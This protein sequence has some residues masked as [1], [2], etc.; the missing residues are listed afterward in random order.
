MPPRGLSMLAM[1]KKAIDTTRGKTN[2]K[3]P[4][5]L[6]SRAPGEDE[7]DPFEYRARSRRSLDGPHRLVA[8][9]ARP[10]RGT[11]PSKA[12]GWAANSSPRI[13]MVFRASAR[14]SRTSER[15]ASG[16]EPSGRKRHRS[17]KLNAQALSRSLSLRFECPRIG[18]SVEASDCR[19]CRCQQGDRRRSDGR[20]GEQT[21]RL[22][23][24]PGE[25]C[26]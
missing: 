14:L 19:W 17:G 23:R 2:I 15:I 20:R 4:W 1:R 26:L 5:A 10:V 21:V 6:A 8:G 12:T 7:N 9:G 24:H 11:L 22:R 3:M 25:Q 13:G 16:T 18:T